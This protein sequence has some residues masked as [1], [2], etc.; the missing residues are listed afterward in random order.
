MMNYR[1]LGIVLLFAFAC[2]KPEENF[3]KIPSEFHATIQERITADS[4]RS[5]FLEISSI[6]P[7]YCQSDS[8]VYTTVRE[9]NQVSILI[10]DSYKANDC[11]QKIYPLKSTISLP[12]FVDTLHIQIALGK[13]S[14]IYGILTQN[15]KSYNLEILSGS[16]LQLKFPFTYK[17]PKNLVWGYAYPIGNEMINQIMLQNFIKDIEFD[18]Y[19]NWLPTGYYS[20]FQIKENNSVILTD[21]PG[22]AGQF[23]NFYYTHAWSLQEMEAFFRSQSSKYSNLVGY[24]V[25]TG[26][27][28]QF[29]SN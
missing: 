8:L 4:T 14:S 13:A 27:G 25:T 29:L 28:A 11:I 26:C 10:L 23:R 16:G 15:A 6:H 24:K 21:N 2:S 17:I 18:C 9:D 19:T 20:Y 5:L 1:I 22:F 12:Q 7:V 3:I